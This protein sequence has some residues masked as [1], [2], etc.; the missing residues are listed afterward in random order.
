MARTLRAELK[1]DKA[2]DDLCDRELDWAGA[3]DTTWLGM[4]TG[5]EFAVLLSL[6][7]GRRIRSGGLSRAPSRCLLGKR[8]ECSAAAAQM[9]RTSPA[10]TAASLVAGGLSSA[11]SEWP[12]RRFCTKACPAMTTWAVRSVWS[13]AHRSLSTLEL[14]VLGFDRIVGVLLDV[15]SGRGKQS[16]STAG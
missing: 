11:M 1:K 12:R 5:G 8:G 6:A 16:S 13:P 4:D 10:K 7:T 9:A 15:V 14:A 2:E 3:D